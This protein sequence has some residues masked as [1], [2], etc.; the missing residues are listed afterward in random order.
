M[1]RVLGLLVCIV[2]WFVAVLSVK[3]SGAYVQLLVATLGFVIAGIGAMVIIN[4]Y[5]LKH[6]IWK[7]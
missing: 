3:V 7:E 6:A 1:E 4:R 5:H 2:G